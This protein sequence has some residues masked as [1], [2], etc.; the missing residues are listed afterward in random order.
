MMRIAKT[1]KL[2][3]GSNKRVLNKDLLAT[4]QCRNLAVP[5]PSNNTSTSNESN[6]HSFLSNKEKK[7][8]PVN[9]TVGYI[10]SKNAR[11][12]PYS[13]AFRAPHQDVNYTHASLKRHAEAL[14]CGYVELG[15]RV[16]DRVGVVQGAT[17]EQFLIQLSCAKIGAIAVQFQGVTSAKDLTRY[18]DL[19]RP[20][21]LI[22][23]AKVGKIDYSKIVQE[24]LPE[25]ADMATMQTAVPFKSRRFPFLK[26]IFFTC[27][28][29]ME[30]MPGTSIFEDAQLFGPFGYY[31]GPLRRIAFKLSPNT[32]A[33]IVVEGGI[34]KGKNFVLTQ[35][36]ILNAAKAVA[37]SIQLQQG[38]VVFVPHYQQS[39]FGIIANFSAFISGAT[40]D[41]PTREF[42]AADVLKHLGTENCTVLFIRR[43]DIDVLLAQPTIDKFEKLRCIVTDQI[44][45]DEVSNLQKKFPGTKVKVLGGLEES[46]GLLTIDGKLISGVEVKVTRDSDDRIVHKDTYG[47]LRVRGPTV[48]TKIWNDIGLMNADVDEEGWV[49]TGRIAKID[50]NDQLIVQ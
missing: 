15:L 36:N 27:D 17:A 30:P 5:N 46:N 49:R 1:S 29:F 35:G 13:N 16:G 50:A 12:T 21:F 43:S 2:F 11:T 7:F 26:Y 44:S 9:N 41:F 19:F 3:L 34:D 20:R 6:R 18:L 39:S 14:A 24:T 48:S 25:L 31:E 22:L 28:S 40:V 23:P 10:L 33:A 4:V 8:E 42:N 47:D 38:D 45:Q 32:P 37:D